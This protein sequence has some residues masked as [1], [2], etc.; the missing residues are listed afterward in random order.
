M[1]ISINEESGVLV[2]SGGLV[3]QE[4]EEAHHMI[5]EYFRTH[6]TLL[7]DLKGVEDCDTAGAQLLLSLHKSAIKAAKNLKFKNVSAVVQECW[8]R[9]GLPK[10]V[11]ENPVSQNE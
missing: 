8:S 5:L 1:R 2:I 10:E 9:L 6:S 4:S 7:L 3:I 11:L